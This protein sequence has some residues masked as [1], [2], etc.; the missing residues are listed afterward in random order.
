ML[1][2][3]LLTRTQLHAVQ[4]CQFHPAYLP[5]YRDLYRPTYHD[6]VKRRWDNNNVKNRNYVT[7]DPLY[8]DHEKSQTNGGIK[9][10][11]AYLHD[12]AD[13]AIPLKD[14][15]HLL[16]NMAKQDMYDPFVYEKF[17]ATM[18]TSNSNHMCSR[19]AFGA[20]WAYYKT[21]MGTRYGIDFWESQLEDNLEGLHAQEV[22]ELMRAFRDNRSLERQH[23][24][25]LL[26]TQYKKCL[27]G[28]WKNEVIYN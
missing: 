14:K 6:F 4:A 16:Y 19:M 12:K 28:K 1:T 20:L 25:N 22:V 26:D 17:E 5:R 2:K 27:I 11:I 7:Q 3:A 18:K 15:A 24:R 23:M 21:N 10:L 13:Y 8:F 9:L